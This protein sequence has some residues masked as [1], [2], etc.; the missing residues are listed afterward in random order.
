MAT[1]IELLE[2]TA[3]ALRALGHQ[4]LCLDMRKRLFVTL[5]ESFTEQDRTAFLMKVAPHGKFTRGKNS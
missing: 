4:A 1:P 5:F 3:A 2:Y